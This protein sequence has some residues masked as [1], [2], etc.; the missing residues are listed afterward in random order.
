[1]S[2][3]AEILGVSGNG[4]TNEVLYGTRGYMFK[5]FGDRVY[6]FAM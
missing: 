2:A 5:S 3:I 6:F 1:M 4:Y